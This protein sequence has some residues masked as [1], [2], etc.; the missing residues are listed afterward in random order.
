MNFIE[1]TID[2]AISWWLTRK[3][4]NRYAFY[5]T[6][7]LRKVMFELNSKYTKLK[8]RFK[9]ESLFCKTLGN[10][11]NKKTSATYNTM[12]FPSAEWCLKYP[13]YTCMI[14]GDWLAEKNPSE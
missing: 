14:V 4:D 13:S 12:W 5:C 3:L 2:R 8:L 9:N 7:E 11:W 6:E 10:R 1:R